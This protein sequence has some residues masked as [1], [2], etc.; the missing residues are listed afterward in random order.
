MNAYLVIRDKYEDFSKA[1]KKI[2]N[3]ILSNPKEVIKLT[4]LDISKNCGVSSAS[5]VRF[6]KDIGFKG[7]DELKI[8]IA[9]KNSDD[10]NKYNI[11]T[12]ISADDNVEELCDKIM[13]LI[14][15]SNEDFF[16][17]LDK[18]ALERA[19]KL[20]RK[21]RNIYMLGI[22]ASSLSAYDLFHKLKR[23][24]FNAFFYEDAHLNAEFFNYLTEEDVV[25]AFSYSGRSNE[26]IYP[27]KIA[28]SKNASII[29]VTRKK[30][31]YL[32]KM[33]DVLITV[34]NNEELTRIGAITSK[35]SSLIVS[36]LLYFGAIQKDF[37]N[38]KE[39]LI[40]TSILT[41]ELKL[42]DEE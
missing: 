41:R 39:N 31:N 14:K 22:G 15:S 13:L 8:S 17:Q 21:A 7:L 5:V 20:I 3:Y 30:T 34:P 27:V 6:A 26:V 1:Y 12:I 38:I 29:A 32:S 25:I 24:N 4:A 42:D 40:K 16:Y 18:D 23:A 33:A 19:F 2:S 36:D 28:S 11:N 9:S 35:Y 37:E 10:D